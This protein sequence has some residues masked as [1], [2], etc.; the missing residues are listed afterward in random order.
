[1]LAFTSPLGTP[2]GVGGD[3]LGPSGDNLQLGARTG[4][5]KE[6]RDMDSEHE[7]FPGICTKKGRRGRSVR[8]TAVHVS[9][10]TKL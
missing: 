10:W 2:F 3:H 9:R 6:G 7:L 5:F 1:M 4:S 8:T